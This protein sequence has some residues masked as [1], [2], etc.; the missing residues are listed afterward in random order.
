MANGVFD[1]ISFEEGIERIQREVGR[2]GDKSVGQSVI[3]SRDASSVQ[4]R[5]RLR[6]SKTPEG[7]SK[8]QLP[9]YWEGVGAQFFISV[10]QPGTAIEEHSHTEGDGLRLIVGGSVK[11]GDQ[12]LGVGDWMYIPQGVRYSL[13]VGELGAIMFY[14]YRCCCVAR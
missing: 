4:L 1:F 7:V 14:C 9:V 10:A 12:E 6:L 2:L 13:D 5:E 3:T 11:F 8:W